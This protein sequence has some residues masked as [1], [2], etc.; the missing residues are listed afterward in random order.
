MYIQRIDLLDGGHRGQRLI[1]ASGVAQQRGLQRQG[2]N[3]QRIR[4]QRIF[5]LDESRIEIAFC[6]QDF[7][8][9]EISC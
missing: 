2:A 6:G 3:V 5:I 8:Q 9:P 7:C 4:L 1:R